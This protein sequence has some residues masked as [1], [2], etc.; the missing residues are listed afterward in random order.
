[1]PDEAAEAA[2]SSLAFRRRRAMSA[3]ERDAHCPL[4]RTADVAAI[5][6]QIL[7][8]RRLIFVG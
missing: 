4:F 5:A 6:R 8:P 7:L 3:P 2:L 1:M